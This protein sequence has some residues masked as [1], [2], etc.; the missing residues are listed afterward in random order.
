MTEAILRGMNTI[1]IADTLPDYQFNDIDGNSYRLS[2]LT[3]DTTLL[4][5]FDPMC[6]GCEAE[7]STLSRL[8]IDSSDRRRMILISRG[9][10]DLIEE[11]R[12]RFGLHTRILHDRDG[13]YMER[14]QITTIPF[15]VVVHNGRAISHI[16]AGSLDSIDLAQFIK[17]GILE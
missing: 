5:F 7:M 16:V 14:L 9:P 1:A 4:V 13:I 11:A 15:N 3:S 2:A 8:G 12:D 6:E 17:T 10:I